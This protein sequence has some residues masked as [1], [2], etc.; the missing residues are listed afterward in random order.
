MKKVGIFLATL[1]F[2]ALSE[3]LNL[4]NATVKIEESGNYTHNQPCGDYDGDGANDILI[5]GLV[6]SSS[7]L[8]NHLK[9]VS[10][11]KVYSYKK[12]AVLLHIHEELADK[13]Y[14]TVNLFSTIDLDNDGDT[15]IIFRDYIFDY[16]S[17][18]VVKK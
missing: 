5:V 11:F 3:Y 6:P 17:D 16:A 15:E 18:G 9:L 2:I 13:Y 1:T 14:S 10:Y 8:D 12:R 7:G 4:D